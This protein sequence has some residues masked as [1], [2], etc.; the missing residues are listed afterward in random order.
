MFSKKVPKS[1]KK[2][3]KSAQKVPKT[4]MKILRNERVGVSNPKDL[5]YESHALT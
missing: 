1:A 4:F 5:H 3:Q 2:C